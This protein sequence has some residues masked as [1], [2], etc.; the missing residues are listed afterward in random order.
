RV[1]GSAASICWA[2]KL[3]PVQESRGIRRGASVAP[4]RSVASPRPWRRPPTAGVVRLNR[5]APDICRTPPLSYRGDVAHD[6]PRPAAGHR[7]RL[8][9]AQEPGAGAVLP[10]DLREGA[11]LL[12]RGQRGTLHRGAASGSRPGGACPEEGP[13]G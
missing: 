7:P 9:A 4:L 2:T 3:L 11:R 12:S 10:A 13:C 6:N 5:I 8:S 1:R